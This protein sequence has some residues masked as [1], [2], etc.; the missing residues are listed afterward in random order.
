MAM[1]GASSSGPGARAERSDVPDGPGGSELA[2]RADRTP[3]ADRTRHADLPDRWG[4]TLVALLTVGV[5]LTWLPGMAG[6]LGDNHEGRILARHALNVT[7]A[8]SDG[9]A[10]SGWLSDWSP[11]VG[12]DGAQTAYAHHPPLLNLGYY[13]A[14]RLSPLDLDVTMRL[15]STLTGVLLLPLGAAVL[16]RRGLGWGPVLVATTAVAITPLFWVYGRLS[17][18]VTLLLAMTLVI[19]RLAEDRRI[20]PGELVLAALV[21]VAAI[22]AGYLGMATAALLGLWLLRERGLDRIT[23]SIGAAM[24]V[25]ATISLGYVIGRTGAARVGEQLEMRTTGGGFTTAEFL[26][27]IGEWATALLPGWWRWGLLPLALVMGI[28]DPRTRPLTV[29]G[30]LVTVGYVGGL[31]N[32]AFIHDYWI[33]PVLLPVWFGTAAAV[34]FAVERLHRR[35][36]LGLAAGLIAV[37]VVAGAGQ[38]IGQQVP[39]RYLLGPQ[40]AGELARD[41]GPAPGQEQAWRTTGIPAPRWLS[42]YWELPPAVVSRDT[43]GDLP[44]DDLVMVAIDRAPGWLGPPE[45]LRERAVEVAGGYALLRGEDVAAAAAGDG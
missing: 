20:R 9:V 32:G 18:N 22:V 17:A 35:Q 30:V 13:L 8:L 45:E 31:P 41:H 25:G 38:G 7:N 28:R 29:I 24:A 11:Y 37:L 12:D 21:S 5:L 2:D 44:P 42:L 10:G 23:L 34:A 14:A 3:R 33:L 26:A 16:H 39:G 15:W 40:A 4:W 27:R 36:G 6:A 43:A 19:V 1:P